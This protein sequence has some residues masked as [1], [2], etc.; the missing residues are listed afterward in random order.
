MTPQE[1]R[2]AIHIRRRELMAA[3][4]G[5]AAAWPLSVLAEQDKVVKIGVL[6]LGYPDP[7]IFIM[8]LL[9]QGMRAEPDPRSGAF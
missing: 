3:L 5:A 7:S 2:L 9:A 1:G 4:G 8:R 6:V